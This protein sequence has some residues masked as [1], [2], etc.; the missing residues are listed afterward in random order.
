MSQQPVRQPH[1]TP[2]DTGQPLPHGAW[3]AD[4]EQ[5]SRTGP[6][7]SAAMFG[8]LR[9]P[10]LNATPDG[11]VA[12]FRD[13]AH[14][15]GCHLAEVFV[16][17]DATA[18]AAFDSLITAAKHRPGC[19]IAVPSIDHLAVVGSAPLDQMLQRITGA[20]IYEM[21]RELGMPVVVTT[22]RQLAGKTASRPSAVV[23]RS[24]HTEAPGADG[25]L[26]VL[27]RS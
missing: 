18:P 19:V 20:R 23:V 6:P 14:R 16:E 15:T 1:G 3:R 25:Q 11:V 13:Y 27:P 10:L 24:R 12:L 26:A 9:I 5:T 8:Y 2:P 7:G 17:Q 4:S 22:V 21:N